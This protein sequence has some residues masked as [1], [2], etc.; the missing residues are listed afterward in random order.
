MPDRKARLRQDENPPYPEFA[1]QMVREFTNAISEQ[2]SPM[3]E[4]IAAMKYAMDSLGSQSKQ[5]GEK[6][7]AIVGLNHS[8]AALKTESYKHDTKFETID[9][10]LKRVKWMLLGFGGILTI[11]GGISMILEI[12]K[13]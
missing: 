13:Y 1:I 6:L 8:V 5:H 4:D 3:R 10:H 11:F 2:I 9:G 7:E 12:L